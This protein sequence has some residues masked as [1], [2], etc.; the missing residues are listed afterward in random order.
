M[1]VYMGTRI[2]GMETMTSSS[3]DAISF[4]YDD[5]NQVVVLL[6]ELEDGRIVR[7][8]RI[9]SSIA[10][11]FCTDK[12]TERVVMWPEEL[13]VSRVGWRESVRVPG[14]R[15]QVFIACSE[16]YVVYKFGQRI[17]LIEPEHRQR[18]HFSLF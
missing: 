17:A 6:A 8:A 13:G 15:E 14:H 2:T 10:R 11:I 16:K 9:D 4:S 5:A 12:D 1:G 7:L 18:V 3:P